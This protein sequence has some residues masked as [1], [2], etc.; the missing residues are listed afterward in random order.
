MATLATIFSRFTSPA[1]D[2]AAA[3]AVRQRPAA[4][5]F[6]LRPIP[7]EDLFFFVKTIDNT[8]VV[9]EFDPVAP[10]R[11]WNMI[12]A[13]SAA[14]VLFI[15]LLLPGAYR[16]LAGYQ[17][18]ALRL[19]QQV[20]MNERASLELQEA[21]LVSPARLE[22]LARIQEFVDPAPGHV[23]Y[24]NSQEGSLALNVPKK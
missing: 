7:N 16:M 8:R 5:P 23:I 10:Q 1:T 3:P 9:R 24:L 20:L 15:G 18:E 14:A 6:R 2:A 4:D 21:K 12:G 17:I 22:E 13:G 11:C 19:E